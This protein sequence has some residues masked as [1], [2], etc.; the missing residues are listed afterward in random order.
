MIGIIDTSALLR[1]FIPEGAIPEGLEDFFQGVN[2][3]RNWALA[4]ELLIA[5]AGN[6]IW[7]YIRAGIMTS[8]EGKAMFKDIADMPVRLVGHKK[9]AKHSLELAET[10]NM[11]VY[12]SLYLALALEQGGTVFTADKKLLETAKLLHLNI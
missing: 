6:V 2:Q 11:T 3:G 1:L 9:L 5:E 4:P 10:Y 7:K 8:E 12:D